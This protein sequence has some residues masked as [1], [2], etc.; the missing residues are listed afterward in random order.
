MI[1]FDYLVC[2]FVDL[3]AR[4]LSV[5]VLLLLLLLLLLLFVSFFWLFVVGV[6]FDQGFTVLFFLGVGVAEF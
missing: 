2:C 3:S 6:G 1:C 4:L 5:F